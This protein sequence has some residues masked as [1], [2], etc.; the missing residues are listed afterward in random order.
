MTNEANQTIE[1][2]PLS[3]D[4][5][6]ALR[7]TAVKMQ[8]DFR[9]AK[10]QMTDLDRKATALTVMSAIFKAQDAVEAYNAAQRG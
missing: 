8:A 7:A 5:V 10:D 2:A 1:N 6:K 4:E 9:A 3:F